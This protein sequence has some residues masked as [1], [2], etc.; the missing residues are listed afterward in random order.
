[1]EATATV[2]E[3]GGDRRRPADLAAGHLAKVTLRSGGVKSALFRGRGRM[4]RQ[5]RTPRLVLQGIGLPGLWFLVA[6]DYAAAVEDL[7]PPPAEPPADAPE[8]AETRFARAAA[9]G[10]RVLVELRNHL[11][12]SGYYCGEHGN[13]FYGDRRGHLLSFQ[14][15]SPLVYW[16]D[17]ALLKRLRVTV[18]GALGGDLDLG[19]ITK[20]GGEP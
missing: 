13:P 6:E 15:Q 3:I 8:A 11:T 10:D 4:S 1:M 18:P 17:D 16:F 7:G 12:Y 2:M 14:R 19:T 5:P 20:L 9:A